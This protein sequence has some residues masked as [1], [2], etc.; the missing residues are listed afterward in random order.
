MK[1]G[2]PPSPRPNKE[3]LPPQSSCRTCQSS[4]PAKE[5]PT[6]TS[7]NEE[8]PHPACEQEHKS[9][10]SCTESCMS[11]CVEQK[12][13]RLCTNDLFEHSENAPPSRQGVY[14]YI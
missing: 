6:T 7:D 2:R 10:H 12:R 9:C 3:Q 5:Q 13:S 4:R 8:Q 1:V 14:H 11:M